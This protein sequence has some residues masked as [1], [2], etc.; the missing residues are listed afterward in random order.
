M[1][2]SSTIN[3]F[4]IDFLGVSINGKEMPSTSETSSATGQSIP[5]NIEISNQ[6]PAELKD[7]TLSIQFYQDYQNGTSKFQ[8]ETRVALSGPNKYASISHFYVW[9]RFFMVL[10][11][12]LDSLQSAYQITEN[13]R[14]RN[15][16]VLGNFLYGWPLQNKHRMQSFRFIII[17]RASFNECISPN[18]C[19]KCG[20]WESRLTGLAF[21]SSPRNHRDRTNI[22]KR[23]QNCPREEWMLFDRTSFF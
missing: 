4:E 2:M 19:L 20:W 12:S 6:S 7:L 21:H 15:T 10:I 18:V 17:W 3:S 8:L 11:F 5:F 1:E 9:I 14:D 16:W 22:K 23:M 13:K